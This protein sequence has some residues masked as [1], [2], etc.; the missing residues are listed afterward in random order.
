MNILKHWWNIIIEL[1]S[2]IQILDPY[3]SRQI[4]S[5]KH[6][7]HVEYCLVL[8]DF[9]HSWGR[10]YITTTF[11]D[12]LLHFIVSFIVIRT[13]KHKSNNVCLHSMVVISCL[14]DILMMI[15]KTFCCVQTHEWRTLDLLLRF[16]F[17]KLFFII[18]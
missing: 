18:S 1:C 13:I 2:A 10:L 3:F 9:L 14:R 11:V 7:L 8:F 6:I 4:F 5:I 15:T 17:S 12:M 16:F